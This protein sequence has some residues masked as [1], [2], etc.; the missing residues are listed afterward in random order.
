MH[1]WNWRET[2]R[3]AEERSELMVWLVPQLTNGFGSEMNCISLWYT[4]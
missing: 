1:S 2:L 4:R 3:L